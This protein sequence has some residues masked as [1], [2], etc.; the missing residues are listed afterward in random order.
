MHL[1]KFI[2]A[3]AGLLYVT[4]WCP[5]IGMIFFGIAVWIATGDW[6]LCSSKYMSNDTRCSFNF[7][8]HMDCRHRHIHIACCHWCLDSNQPK[9]KCRQCQDQDEMCSVCISNR[10]MCKDC[11]SHRLWLIIERFVWKMTRGEIQVLISSLHAIAAELEDYKA[12][13]PQKVFNEISAMERF[14]K[15][16]ETTVNKSLRIW[17]NFAVNQVKENKWSQTSTYLSTTLRLANTSAYLMLH[18]LGKVHL[19]CSRRMS[20]AQ[21]CFTNGKYLVDIQA[22]F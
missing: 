3:M 18:A 11:K 22:G 12:I 17:Y 1:M 9:Q 20:A 5:A 15:N 10:C 14:L 4:S 13:V 19:G 21:S 8:M 2:L 7:A 16:D 6:R